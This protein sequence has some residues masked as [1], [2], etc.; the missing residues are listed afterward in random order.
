MTGEAAAFSA[1]A[2]LPVQLVAGRAD[3]PERALARAVLGQAVED[4]AR[5]DRAALRWIHSESRAWPFAFLNLC[6]GLAVEAQALRRR[7][8]RATRAR[9]SRLRA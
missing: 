7:V 2:V 4:A 9:R 6:D 8:G 5:G 3:S 1:E